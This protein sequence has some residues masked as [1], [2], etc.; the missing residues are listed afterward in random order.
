MYYKQEAKIT[1]TKLIPRQ[2]NKAS[3]FDWILVG[4]IKFSKSRLE[5]P[6]L[7][8]LWQ[9]QS[10]LKIYNIDKTFINNM[11][12]FGRHKSANEEKK[13]E[14]SCEHVYFFTKYLTIWKCHLPSV[15]VEFDDMSG[16]DLQRDL[17]AI[18]S[19]ILEKSP[20]VIS[21]TSLKRFDWEPNLLLRQW[22]EC[23][24]SFDFLVRRKSDPEWSEQVHQQDGWLSDAELISRTLPSAS[25]S[26]WLE[27]ERRQIGFVLLAKPVWIKTETIQKYIR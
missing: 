27:R 12:Q 14:I 26:K 13:T 18:R 6:V 15:N 9:S 7:A 23:E 25:E 11:I 5:Y 2:N 24:A 21:I 3:A 17:I 8:F 1:F 4:Q 16:A 22:Y 19:M 20:T 10:R